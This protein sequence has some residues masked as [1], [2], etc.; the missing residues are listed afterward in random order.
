MAVLDIFGPK[1]ETNLDVLLSS[2]PEP[3]IRVEWY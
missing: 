3:K 2:R 1:A